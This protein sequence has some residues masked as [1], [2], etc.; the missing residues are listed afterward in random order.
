MIFLG[1]IQNF[2]SSTA[3]TR[4]HTFRCCSQPMSFLWKRVCLRY[5]CFS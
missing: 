5:C 3:Q 2:A 4:D 1:H